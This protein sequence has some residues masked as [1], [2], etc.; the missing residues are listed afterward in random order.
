MREVDYLKRVKLLHCG[1]LHLDAPFTSLADRDG[2][3]EQRRQELKRML[4]MIVDLA[5]SEQVDLLLICGDLYE[6]GYVRKST[7]HFINE[8]FQ[9]IRDIPVLIIPGNH[10]PASPDSLYS[11]CDWSENVRILKNS[12]DYYEHVKTGTRVFAGMP[13]AGYLSGAAGHPPVRDMDLKAVIN[14]LM[15]HGTLDMSFNTDA[16]QPITSAEL[17][18][19][20]F[21]Y[22]ALGHFHSVIQGA[23]RSGRIYNAGSPEPL[24]FDEEGKHGVYLVTIEKNDRNESRIDAA[25]RELGQRCFMKLEVQAGGCLTDEQT[26]AVVAAAIESAGCAGDLYSI[27]LQGYLDRSF[28]INTSYVADLLKDKAYYVKITDNTSPD[29]DFGFIAREPGLR[30]LFA[31]KMLDRAANAP[32]EEGRQLVMRALY[33]GME[34]IDEG[35]VCI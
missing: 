6:H 33:Y 23:G 10:D 11:S 2:G 31:K 13:P 30:G 34:A 32:D 18:T 21:D 8:Q 14:V 4:G 16:Y 5:A 15:Y 25:F 28:R 3:P 35:T 20:G 27:T 29:Y 19:C 7:F 17:D 22:C 12:D 24:G 1:D 26:A 9:K